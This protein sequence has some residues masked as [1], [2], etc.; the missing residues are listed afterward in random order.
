MTLATEGPAAVKTRRERGLVLRVQPLLG[1]GTQ[2]REAEEPTLA[3]SAWARPR[4][5]S[6]CREDSGCSQGGKGCC[7]WLGLVIPPINGSGNHCPPQGVADPCGVY[8]RSHWITGAVAVV[9]ARG[10]AVT[11]RG[12]TTVAALAAGQEAAVVSLAKR[13]AL[14]SRSPSQN[15][16]TPPWG[17]LVVV[18][19]NNPTPPWGKLAVVVAA[20][21]RRKE[22]WSASVAPASCSW[23]GRSKWQGKGVAIGPGLRWYFPEQAQTERRREEKSARVKEMQKREEQKKAMEH[24][25]K[26][27]VGQSL[28][29]GWKESGMETLQEVTKSFSLSLCRPNA[30]SRLSPKMKM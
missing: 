14:R 13:A 12:E 26:R 18:C 8:E 20:A 21:L 15:H 10:W 25:E 27:K 9:A 7:P 16:P 29:K 6:C 1:A 2:W 11:V 28:N 23:L 24:G 30:S 4:V 22:G 19:Q 3:R 17:T 5:A